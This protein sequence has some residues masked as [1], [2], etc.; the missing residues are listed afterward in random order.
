MLWREGMGWGSGS[1][2][3]FQGG[4]TRPPAFPASIQDLNTVFAPWGATFAHAW[5]L[6]EASGNALDLATSGAIPL[7]PGAGGSAPTRAVSTGLVGD[8]KGAQFDAFGSQNFAAG[9]AGDLNVTTGDLL[10]LMTIRLT[11]DS[12]GTLVVFNKMGATNRWRMQSKAGGEMMF[13]AYDGTT[14]AQ[15]TIAV[16]HHGT[17]YHD[18]LCILKRGTGVVCASDLGSG[19]VVSAPANTIDTSGVFYLGEGFGSCSPMIVTFLAWGTTTG[20]VVTGR[21]DAIAAWRRSRGA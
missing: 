5:T 12:G 9:A 18:I 4:G 1:G 21:T 13:E 14:L 3:P 16:A 2:V 11:S 10:V 15:S 17:A 20:T 19:S 7:V 6:G 8:D